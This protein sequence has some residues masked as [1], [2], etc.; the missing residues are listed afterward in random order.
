MNARILIGAVL[1]VAAVV[2]LLLLVFPEF[3]QSYW[4]RIAFTFEEV[5][6]RPDRV[7]SGRVDTWRSL[8]AFISAHPWQTIVG[9]GYKTLPYTEHP[10]RPV[11]A[12]NMY[13]SAL[14]ETGLAGLAA[15][16]ALNAAILR[17]T[18]RAA[19]NAGSFYATWIFCFWT[20]FTVQMLSG[21]VLTYWRILPVFFWVLGQAVREAEDA[22]SPAGS[23]L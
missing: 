10:G 6:S 9:I 7:L 14:V 3:A 1:C 2:V 23:V 16:I 18:W 5:L 4:A 21:D 17:A 11:I 15:L 20:G 13:L 12:D 8:A 19:R 22:N